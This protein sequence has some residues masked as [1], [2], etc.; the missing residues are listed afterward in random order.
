MTTTKGELAG[1]MEYF[2]RMYV[3]RK[4]IVAEGRGGG[5][6]EIFLTDGM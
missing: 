1:A 2:C 4:E 6:V 3:A 5:V